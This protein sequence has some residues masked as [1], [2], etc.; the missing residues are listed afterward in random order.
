MFGFQRLHRPTSKWRLAYTKRNT[1]DECLTDLKRAH[2]NQACFVSCNELSDDELIGIIK[3]A[4][5]QFQNF[6]NAVD[7]SK[8]VEI[9]THTFG[10]VRA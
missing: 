3:A 7:H 8:R 5:E 6:K 9:I 1:I 4:K 10:L 2:N